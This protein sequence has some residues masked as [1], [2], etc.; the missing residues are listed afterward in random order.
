MWIEPSDSAVHTESVDLNAVMPSALRAM[1]ERISSETRSHLSANIDDFLD[2]TQEFVT[3]SWPWTRQEGR[4]SG[5]PIAE[6]EFINF[7]SR[8][9]SA[10]DIIPVLQSWN[11]RWSIDIAIL[12]DECIFE[13]DT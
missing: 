3:Q 2:E 10:N 8:V 11:K 5:V 1:L 4:Y 13:L 7:A 6:D 12:I 9:R